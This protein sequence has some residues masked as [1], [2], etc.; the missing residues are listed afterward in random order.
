VQSAGTLASYSGRITGQPEVIRGDPIAPITSCLPTNRPQVALALLTGER[1]RSGS[2]I[3]VCVPPPK[4]ASR[5]IGQT[6]SHYKITGKL[7]GGGMGV[8]YKAPNG[9]KR[10]ES[11]VDAREDFCRTTDEQQGVVRYERQT[12][13][14]AL[15][16]LQLI[17]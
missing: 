10:I 8:V 14:P 1:V 15:P 17:I 11:T 6:I 2:A 9:S 3:A 4:I 7:G 12:G 5:M 13:K 16:K